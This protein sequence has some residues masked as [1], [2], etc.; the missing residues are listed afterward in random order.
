MA[1]LRL[2]VRLDG[3]AV[4]HSPIAVGK[5]IVIG[6]ALVQ[7]HETGSRYRY[8]CRPWLHGPSRTS[9]SVPGR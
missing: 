9:P 3:V 2:T 8:S 4:A 5:A 1:Q 6:S 7:P